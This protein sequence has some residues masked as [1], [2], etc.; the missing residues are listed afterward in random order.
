[1]I[2][3]T[4]NEVWEIRDR[5]PYFLG[6]IKTPQIIYFCFTY[7]H[8]SIAL[9]TAELSNFIFAMILVLYSDVPSFIFYTYLFCKVVTS[10]LSA[11]F[12]Y[13]REKDAF[14]AKYPKNV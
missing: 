3:L 14:E 13:K 12:L 9:T 7:L 2:K 5:Q 1:M 4:Q 8:R 11:P 6:F 10:I